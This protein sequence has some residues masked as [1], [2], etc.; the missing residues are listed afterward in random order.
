[1]PSNKL[2]EIV[3]SGEGLTV[4]FKTCRT[5]VNRDVYESIC[6]FLNRKGGHLVLGV[7]D[8]GAIS[9]I[10]PLALSEIKKDLVTTLNNPQKINPPLYALPEEFKVNGKMLLYLAVP[11][12]SQVHLCKS[13]IFDRRE[14]GDLDITN[15]SN[16]VANLYIRKQSTFSENQIYPYVRL[17]DLRSDL[18]QQVKTMSREINPNHPWRGLN[19]ESLL[20]SA[21]LYQR[22]YQTDKQGYTLAATF[23]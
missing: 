6:A 14:D 8:D 1:M 2:L 15:Q 22:D 21:R 12:S 5:K 4:E 11:E 7:Q 3:K 16:A 17:R 9:G 20:Q 13:K 23:W 18:I 19:D 10:D